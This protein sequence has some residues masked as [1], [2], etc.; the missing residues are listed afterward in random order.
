MVPQKAEKLGASAK[1]LIDI[2]EKHIRSILEYAV[3]AWGPMITVG[4]SLD[5]ERVQKVAYCI[6]FGPSSYR[7]TLMFQNKLTLEDRRKKLC[8]NFANNCYKSPIFSNWFS[9]KQKIVNTRGKFQFK[10]VQA[11]CERW[12]RSPIPYMTRLLNNQ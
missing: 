12:R 5:L 8:Q 2:Y 3:P 6:I 9:E 11:R 7:K 10:D 4:N 1:I